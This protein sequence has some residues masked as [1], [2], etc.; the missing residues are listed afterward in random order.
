MARA[1]PCRARRRADLVAGQ[2]LVV[3]GFLPDRE[4]LGGFAEE[5]GCST[6]GVAQNDLITARRWLRV[7]AEVSRPASSQPRNRRRVTVDVG[8]AQRLRRDALRP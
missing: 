5:V 3:R 2:V 6:A 8:Q 7:V 4:D 1:L